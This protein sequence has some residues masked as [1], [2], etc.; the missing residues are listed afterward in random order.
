MSKKSKDDFMSF[1]HPI[2][3]NYFMDKDIY[4]D[5][6][7]LDYHVI[8]DKYMKFNFESQENITLVCDDKNLKF[9]VEAL[10]NLI[11]KTFEYYEN[12]YDFKI[13]D[14]IIMSTETMTTKVGVEIGMKKKE[15]NE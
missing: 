11:I 13:P 9:F 3:P 6:Q 15:N 12:E 14:F 7:F 8:P 1:N 10:Y 2:C 4:G 5:R